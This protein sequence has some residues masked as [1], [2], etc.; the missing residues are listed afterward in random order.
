MHIYDR[1]TTRRK[2]W[3]VRINWSRELTFSE[4]QSGYI[5]RHVPNARGVYCIYAKDFKFPHRA[6]PTARARWSHIVYIGCG[7]LD[8]R[9]CAHLK[10]KKNDRLAEYLN[11]YNLAYRYD[12]IDD[13]DPEYDWPRVVEAGL[14]QKFRGVFEEL[15]PANKRE[16][17]LP[18]MD[19]DEFYLDESE[20]FSILWR[21]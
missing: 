14:L 12:R 15:P 6:S 11:K 20:N 8:K 13:S 9:L 10:Y 3:S 1:S 18:A 5:M 19:L 2:I 4:R 16:E 7:W 21:E 17:V